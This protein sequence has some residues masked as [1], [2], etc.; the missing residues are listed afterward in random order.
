MYV[1][2]Y[3]CVCVCISVFLHVYIY[4]CVPVCVPVCACLFVCVYTFAVMKCVNLADQLSH[5]LKKEIE[6][7]K[8]LEREI[9]SMKGETMRNRVL[10]FK[11]DNKIIII[12][13]H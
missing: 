5:Y 6:S 13:K 4:V 11:T 12:N 2:T 8:N 7:R 9:I 3:V 10:K 1:R